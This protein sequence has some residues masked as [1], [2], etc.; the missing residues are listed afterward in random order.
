VSAVNVPARLGKRAVRMGGEVV[1]SNTDLNLK[2]EVSE[3]SRYNTNNGEGD[4][5]FLPS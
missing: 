5:L 1:V 4:G 3:L 2:E